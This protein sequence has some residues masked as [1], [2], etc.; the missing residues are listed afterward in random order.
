MKL[1]E[2][3]EVLEAEIEHSK[4]RTGQKLRLEE[5]KNK[6]KDY[7]GED[8]LISS[9]ELVEKIKSEVEEFKMPTG[10]NQIDSILGG[11]RL[12]QLVTISATTG[13][14]KTTFAMEI[15]IRLKEHNPVWIPFEEGAEE[16]IRKFLER[17]ETPPLFYTPKNITG[18]SV[19]WI[20]QRIIE[21]KVKHNSK[22]FFI[23][24]LHF[25]VPF[26]GDRHDL[27]V[28]RTMRDL[29][30]L[31][32]KWE[33]CIFIICHLK[34]VDLD[35]MP[36]LDALRDSSF[37]GQESDTVIMLW[38]LNKEG[39]E[40]YVKISVQKNRRTGKLGYSEMIFQDGRFLQK[41][42][43]DIKSSYKGYE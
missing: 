37:I 21:G 10:F 26:A 38:R 22:V 27:A 18:K 7:N 11:F 8:A 36:T 25:I 32:K 13:S 16:L 34:K 39:Y 23:D 1:T 2:Y 5:I 14:G 33:V 28:G 9:E 6:Y 19:N 41:A 17:N 35:K 3:M 40:N 31:A 20:E 24:H 43:P 42:F 12:G 15:T 29:K 30:E 4:N